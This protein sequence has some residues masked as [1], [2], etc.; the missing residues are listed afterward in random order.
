MAGAARRAGTYA[1]L[2]AACTSWQA[3]RI[4]AQVAADSVRALCSQSAEAHTTEDCYVI[5]FRGG[6]R[7]RGYAGT[8]S[9]HLQ[10]EAAHR[11]GHGADWTATHD[12]TSPDLTLEIVHTRTQSKKG[13]LAVCSRGALEPSCDS[14]LPTHLNPTQ[15]NSPSTQDELVETVKR[16]RADEALDNW[17]GGPFLQVNSQD[18]DRE[19]RV[20]FTTLTCARHLTCSRNTHARTH[21]RTHPPSRAA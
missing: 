12:A 3:E 4:A 2:D 20:L 6:G 7:Q 17:R 1:G 15:P 8:T 14:S 9:N 19:Q 16:Q 13:H 11:S 10:R 21:D 18:W 5:N